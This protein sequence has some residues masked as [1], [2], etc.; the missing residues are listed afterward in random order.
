MDT[1]NIGDYYAVDPLAL[2]DKQVE[3]ALAWFHNTT[4][5]PY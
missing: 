3:L 4:T 2:E 5:T 1:F